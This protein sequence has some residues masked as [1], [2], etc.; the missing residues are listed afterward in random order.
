MNKF[1]N[2]KIKREKNKRIILLI[3][4]IIL[5]IL[6]FFFKYESE[7]TNNNSNKKI[8]DLNSIIIS[9]NDKEDK[10]AYLNIKY[11]PYK[12]A[13]YDDTPNSY[14]IV[15]DDKY[16][17][18]AYM[19]P[20]DYQK[21]SKNDIYSSPKRIEGITKTT[22]EDIKKLAIDAYNG[23]VQDNDKNLT[24]ADFNNYFGSVYLDMTTKYTTTSTILSLIFF[25]LL[26]FGVIIALTSIIEL[27]G[28]SHSIKKLS[29]D[30]IEEIDHEMN[31][32]DAFYYDKASLYLTNNYIINFG[33]R[34]KIINYK[35]ILW[36]YPFEQ[37]T[38]GIKTS[39]SIKVLTNDGKTSI[40][41]T[42]DVITKQKKEIYNEIWDTII[43]KND[44]IL[45]GYT[46]ENITAMNQK[47]KEI[48]K[49]K[50][51]K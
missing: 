37:R 45:T 18:I 20:E 35:D 13:V 5:I 51:K 43:S 15:S 32:Q 47:V 8:T 31:D 6:S 19:S 26:F 7:L 4:G 48:R 29:I 10:F 49:E 22:T 44:Q 3:V 16:M 33:G 27:L 12:F 34:L 21:L 23:S 40:I 25:L 17:Y 24:L 46:K 11:K 41:A 36:I 38:N 28:I 30:K 50:K 14:Y 2:K 9:S 39:Q 42:M 1:T